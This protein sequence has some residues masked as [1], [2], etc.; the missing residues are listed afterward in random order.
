M[1][2]A[3]LRYVEPSQLMR[4]V[5]VLTIAYSPEQE[6]Q[7]MSQERL[8]DSFTIDLSLSK[9]LYLSRLSKKIYSTSAVPR[10]EDKH[11]KSRLIF[12]IGMRNLIGSSDIV[13]NGYESSRLQRYKLAN[14]YYYNRQDTR[15][16]YCYPRTFYVSA[17]IVL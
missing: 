2:Y 16:T 10:F 4:T 11:P 6:A 13:Y 12:R 1:N 17:T 14:K 7:L 8:K 9:T 3:G 5:R 15:Y